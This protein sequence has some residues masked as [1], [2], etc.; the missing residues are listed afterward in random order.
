MTNYYYY[1]DYL[2]K[3]DFA[4]NVAEFLIRF[5]IYN[6]TKFDDKPFEDDF[7]NSHLNNHSAY[8]HFD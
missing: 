5:F 2:H 4:D 6:Y 7:A 1:C 3:D 8:K